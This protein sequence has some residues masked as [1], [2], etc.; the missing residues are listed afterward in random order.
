VPL[1]VAGTYPRYGRVVSETD[2][3]DQPTAA[4]VVLAGGS[5][6]RVGTARNKVL[7]PMAGR[8]V[9]SWSF[10]EAR[11]VTEIGR[12]VLVIRP[13]DRAEIDDFVGRELRD[14]PVDVVVG[15][16]SRHASE[17]SALR[18]LAPAVTAGTVDVIA[19][20]D[21]AR[22]LAS[23]SLLRTVVSTA[24]R[25][26]GAVPALP[27]PL[28]F[29]AALLTAGY[30]SP[31]ATDP[32]QLVCV[33]TPQAFQARP[34]LEAYERAASGGFKGSDTASCLETYGSVPI[35]VVPGEASNLKITHPAD[36]PLAERLM[37]QRH[38]T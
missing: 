13:V 21:A 10:H 1:T 4:L 11:S 38:H 23:P 33:Q 31:L 20:H 26:G 19:L 35:R 18:H 15:G 12:F 34:L 36:L 29:P 27:T 30:Q 24:R 32:N 6:T 22:P 9:L 3:R 14:V 5:G 8:L 17:W 25:I 7:L 37:A 2:R 28:L 16:D